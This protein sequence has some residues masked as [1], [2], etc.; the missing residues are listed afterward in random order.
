MKK[1]TN[2]KTIPLIS[3]VTV[4]YNCVSTIEITIKSIIGQT[5]PN[6]EYIIIDGGSTDGTLD[7]ISRYNKNISYII[8]EPDKG[9][10]DAM[11]KGITQAHG[12]WINFMNAGD[13]FIFPNVLENIFYREYYNIGV[14]FGDKV[15]KLNNNLYQIFAKPFYKVK[16]IGMGINH[17]CIFVRSD[18]AKKHPFCLDFKVSADYNMI[19]TLYKQNIKFEYMQQPIALVE[20]TGFSQRNK[21]LQMH[22]EEIILGIPH[23]SI[24]IYY[25]QFI[26]KKLKELIVELTPNSILEKK[27]SSNN[28]IKIITKHGFCNNMG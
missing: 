19:Y 16:S 2:E 15:I 8:S 27:Y 26:A 24:F 11:N 22:E 10:F 20:K 12:K 25:K 7:I 23:R 9:I 17:Q 1:S 4:T 21:R 13:I 6:I 28:N 18:L 5:Y 3:I 14:I